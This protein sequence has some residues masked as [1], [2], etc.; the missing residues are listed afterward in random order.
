MNV[1][2]LATV[3]STVL[4]CA[5]PVSGQFEPASQPTTRPATETIAAARQR[6]LHLRSGELARRDRAR[7]AAMEMILA[8]GQANGREAGAVLDPVGY[9]SLPLEGDLPDK[10]EKP[11]LPAAFEKQIAGRRPADLGE[12]PVDLIQVV[13]PEGL[14]EQFRAIAT[15]MLPQDLAVV[16]RA[17]TG[18]SAE[19]WITRDACLVVR[20]RGE[21]ATILGG[22]LLEALATSATGHTPQKPSP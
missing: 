20:I 21:K 13:A 10:P 7:L 3:L 4:R 12:L 6:L 2:R 15:W 11:I 22:N 14:R 8:I 18:H 17:P 5:L 9:Q 1:T 16:I 19:D